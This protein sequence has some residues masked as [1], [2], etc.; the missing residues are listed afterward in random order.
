MFQVL[1]YPENQKA[2]KRF[3]DIF[4]TE[5]K[6]IQEM[7]IQIELDSCPQRKGL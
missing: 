1:D 2:I 5:T 7:N 3:C 6:Q 4:G